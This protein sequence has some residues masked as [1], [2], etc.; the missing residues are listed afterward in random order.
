MGR[1]YLFKLVFSIAMF[2]ACCG[3]VFAQAVPRR[4]EVGAQLVQLRTNAIA[5]QYC[6]ACSLRRTALGPTFAVNL[7]RHFALESSLAI[8]PTP[9][10]GMNGGGRALTAASGVR[11]RI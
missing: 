9:I 10:S 6:F 4:F 5:D 11:A 7:N 3:S 1:S 8:T 2:I